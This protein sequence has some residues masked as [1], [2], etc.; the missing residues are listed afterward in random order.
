M[1]KLIDFGLSVLWEK[2]L[3]YMGFHTS[4]GTPYFAAPEI[5]KGYYGYGCDVWSVGVILYILLT[6][7]IPFPG[8]TNAEVIQ[9]I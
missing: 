8:D 6:G 1:L 9:N 5:I 4:V 3:N 2:D 7:C